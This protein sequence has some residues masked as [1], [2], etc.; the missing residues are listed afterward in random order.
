MLVLQGVWV[1]LAKGQLE[2]LLLAL[3]VDWA[4]APTTVQ[5]LL[6]LSTV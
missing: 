2:L 6:E 1:R 5:S 4:N 3:L